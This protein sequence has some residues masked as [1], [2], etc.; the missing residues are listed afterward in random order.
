MNNVTKMTSAITAP[1]SRWSRSIDTT[2]DLI[3]GHFDLDGALIFSDAGFEFDD[4]LVEF[5]KSLANQAQ[6]PPRVNEVFQNLLE[7]EEWQ[8]LRN[9]WSIRDSDSFHTGRG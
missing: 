1:G 3:V 4:A 9:A 8:R 2:C 5:Y 6:A 7:A